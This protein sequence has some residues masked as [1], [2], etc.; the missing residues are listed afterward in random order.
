MGFTLKNNKAAEYDAL[1]FAD[2]AWGLDYDKTKTKVDNYAIAP[3]YP[4]TQD[5]TYSIERNP[6]LRGVT[7]DYVSLFRS[8]RAASI[9]VDLNGYKNLSFSA[10]GTSVVEVTLV[11]K[12]IKEWAKQYR[13]QVRFF[14]ETQAFVI[15]FKGFSNGTEMPLVADDIVDVV[16]TI[17]GDGKTEMPF[18]MQVSNVQF[19][20]KDN[21]KVSTVADGSVQVFPNPASETAEL[22]IDLPEEA[23]SQITLSS[24]RGFQVINRQEHL[25][26]GRNRVALSVLDVPSGIYVATI[27]TAKGK[28]T[29]KIIVQK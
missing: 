8:L 29:A 22:I 2:G 19:D 23:Q 16:F 26:K 14:N 21:Q 12:S 18:E 20:K 27:T 15:P 5:N 7:K 4:S 10:S 3:G 28:I 6:I 25:A 1:Y 9:E 13:T 24:I 11:K 17:K